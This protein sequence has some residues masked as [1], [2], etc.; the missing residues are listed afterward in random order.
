MGRFIIKRKQ[1]NKLSIK[2]QHINNNIEN[3][4]VDKPIVEV[5]NK[6]INDIAV[7]NTKEKIEMANDILNQYEQPKVKKVKK[8][9]GIIERAESSMTIITEDNR[10]LLKD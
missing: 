7:M 9:K 2:R 5:E 8:D 3:K 1:H 6:E 10:E 4:I